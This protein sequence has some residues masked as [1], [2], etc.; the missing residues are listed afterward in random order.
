MKNF[1]ISLYCK[2]LVA[3]LLTISITYQTKAENIES[4]IK[5]VLEKNYKIKAEKEH[6]KGVEEDYKKARNA[7]FI[8]NLEAVAYSNQVDSN[9][10]STP[11]ASEVSQQTNPQGASLNLNYPIFTGFKTT[12]ARKMAK[13]FLKASEENYTIQTNMLLIS[14]IAAYIDVMKN[15]KLLKV[16]EDNEELMEKQY[17]AT[18]ILYR[19]GTKIKTDLLKIEAA[20][21]AAKAAKIMAETEYNNAVNN[22]KRIVQKEP[23]NLEEIDLNYKYEDL[24]PQTKIDFINTV[25]NNSPA[26]KMSE[27]YYRASKDSIGLERG[28]FLPKVSFDASYGQ[29]QD[30]NGLAEAEQ[31]TVGISVQ[32]PIIQRGMQLPEYRKAKH[33]ALKSEFQYFDN[34]SSIIAD[35]E[36][37]WD[38]YQASKTAKDAYEKNVT[39]S[40]DALK[41][42]ETEYRYGTK[43]VLDLIDAQKSYLSAEIDFLDAE[44]NE[45]L[46]YFKILS[47]I[48]SLKDFLVKKDS[49]KD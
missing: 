15:E 11:G 3:F 40:K 20:Y 37:S 22:F 25:K 28:D 7:M 35:A 33:E 38:M 32:I 14:A 8:P 18:K 2:G 44:K 29:T 39:A 9:I 48:G 42:S 21:S 5:E 24:L 1:K 27:Y 41:A 10:I 47:H 26:L 49:K 43:S 17:N 16:K 31:T 46:A 19:S 4:I 30:A 13:N 12:Y 6:L 23:K 45:L 34:K 36:K